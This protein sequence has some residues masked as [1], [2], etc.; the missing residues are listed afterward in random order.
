MKL[1]EFQQ[2]N[3][4]NL[5]NN[6]NDFMQD[7]P[8]FVRYMDIEKTKELICNIL[9][10]E[11]LSN[12]RY[13]RIFNQWLRQLHN[14]YPFQFAS[15]R[16]KLI[17]KDSLEELDEA[18]KERYDD[19]IKKLN[20]N[21]DRLES[22]S[23]QHVENAYREIYAAISDPGYVDFQNYQEDTPYI[24]Q[25]AQ[26]YVAK[27]QL[28]KQEKHARLALGAISK[29]IFQVGNQEVGSNP[30]GLNKRGIGKNAATKETYIDEN[31][32]E[33]TLWLTPTMR[34]ML[35]I[36]KK[37]RQGK[38]TARSAYALV[39]AQANKAC[40]KHAI[41]NVEEFEDP[42][43][44]EERK[45]AFYLSV[46]RGDFVQDK[47]LLKKEQ[48]CKNYCL[49]LKDEIESTQ[50]AIAFGV[51]KTVRGN[52]I[53][54][55]MIKMREAIKDAEGGKISWEAAYH[56]IHDKAVSAKNRR[57]SPR[58]EINLFSKGRTNPNRLYNKIAD[59]RL[60][61]S[62]DQSII[63]LLD[64]V[65]EALQDI[66]DKPQLGPRGIKRALNACL[67]GKEITFKH[68][69]DENDNNRA[70]TY[71]HRPEHIVQAAKYYNEY[72]EDRIDPRLAL[73][74]IRKIFQK[75]SVQTAWHSSTVK[76]T[77]RT[78]GTHGFYQHQ[79]R[80]LSLDLE[81]AGKY[82]P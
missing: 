11:E 43:T 47:A 13:P 50:W 61:C 53:S 1:D 26:S 21:M 71:N 24:I 49:Q 12:V 51:G 22:I 3:A 60:L 38:M 52:R 27:S 64:K 28:P 65:R 74:N 35:E 75:A 10:N 69:K 56:Y 44:G 68:K 32:Q 16:A 82:T 19:I 59:C 20:C 76:P 2:E 73:D 41:E 42:Q 48:L 36:I 31:E 72:K 34:K 46:K 33:Y 57:S 81:E 79:A 6:F 66:L 18:Q 30:Y 58:V 29:A 7:Y 4:R 25:L 55:T 62:A 9:M 45:K 15:F 14:D 80:T 17:L 40:V 39:E 8:E 23:T 67:G 5:I 78:A 63:N 37:A 70:S 77:M 54:P